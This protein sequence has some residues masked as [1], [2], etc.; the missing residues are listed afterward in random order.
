LALRKRRKE[1]FISKEE[2]ERNWD[3]LHCTVESLD[4]EHL[5]LMN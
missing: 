2:M 4:S 5:S 1:E 3:I